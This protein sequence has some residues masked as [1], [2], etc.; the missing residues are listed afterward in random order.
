M[1]CP[2]RKK[3]EVRRFQDGLTTKVVTEEY[4]TD[5]YRE[6]CPFY[7]YDSRGSVKSLCRYPAKGE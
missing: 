6:E 5:C 7:R 2:F 3:K 1:K 4:F